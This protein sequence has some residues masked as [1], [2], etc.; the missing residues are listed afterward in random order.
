MWNKELIKIQ[1]NV[2][3]RRKDGI[4]EED[5]E[6]TRAE[7]KKLT[8]DIAANPTPDAEE[9][10]AEIRKTWTGLKEHI[11]EQNRIQESLLSEVRQLQERYW[12]LKKSGKFDE[13]ARGDIRE[14]LKLIVQKW[15]RYTGHD[16][17]V[18]YGA[19]SVF[20][21]EMKAF[22]AESSNMR[23]IHAKINTT[24]LDSRLLPDNVAYLEWFF[25][26]MT[27]K[28][29]SNA[30]EEL[31]Q[32]FTNMSP[33]EKKI[34]QQITPRM[35][36]MSRAD[37]IAF[38]TLFGDQKRNQKRAYSI[39]VDNRTEWQ[40]A[41]LIDPN[42]TPQIS[43]VVS[44]GRPGDRT[45]SG[46]FRFLNEWESSS[47]KVDLKPRTKILKLFWQVYKD[48]APN[49]MI[50]FDESHAQMTTAILALNTEW[51]YYF[52]G[53]NK[54]K[55]LGKQVSW[56]CIRMDNV[57]I[58]FLSTLFEKKWITKITIIDNIGGKEAHWLYDSWHTLSD[59]QTSRQTMDLQTFLNNLRSFKGTRYKMGWKDKKWID[60]SRLPFESL[61]WIFPQ[62][63]W[64]ICAE[65][66]T[67]TCPQINKRDLQVGDFV[68]LKRGDKAHHMAVITRIGPQIR[69]IE[70]SS[71]ENEV[72][73][74][75]M[76]FDEPIYYKNI[77]V[78]Q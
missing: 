49:G 77:Y 25:S 45:P 42:G 15:Q 29:L 62:F 14:A 13:N 20:A 16:M 6:K 10:Y 73:E 34:L 68:M 59:I 8:E 61:R 63:N 52:H 35:E 40:R 55:D 22:S 30:G 36:R 46:N 65:D 67:R 39:F 66:F 3:E 21:Q 31:L 71:S 5:K 58:A 18:V 26:E 27:D 72:I 2:S 41:Y 23:D 51:D 11:A 28:N 78:N 60:C 74:H 64:E 24:K 38:T 50:D 9:I 76:P 37:Q 48:Q 47:I 17:S 53:T 1:D 75:N 69:I 57:S 12:V 43:F 44:C 7:L 70:A 56:W 4:S 54:E 19:I 32:R 33:Q